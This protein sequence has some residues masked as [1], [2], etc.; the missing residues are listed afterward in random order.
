[1]KYDLGLVIVG[2]ISILWGKY[3]KSE[4]VEPLAG[5]TGSLIIGILS[6]L[7][8]ILDLIFNFGNVP[9]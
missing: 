3:G 7:L 4:W 1:M 2:V 9:R 8:G 6:I 5:R